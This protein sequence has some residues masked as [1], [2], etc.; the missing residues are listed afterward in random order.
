[1]KALD[2]SKRRTALPSRHS[3]ISQETQNFLLHILMFLTTSKAGCHE[4][5]TQATLVELDL[6]YGSLVPEQ[7]MSH[8]IL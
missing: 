3:F 5:E 4:D 1:M 8:L 7:E 2:P 6:K